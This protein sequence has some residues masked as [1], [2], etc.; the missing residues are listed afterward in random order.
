MMR[1]GDCHGDRPDLQERSR[2]MNNEKLQVVADPWARLRFSV[3]GNLLSSPPEYGKLKEAFKELSMKHWKHPFRDE[4]ITFHWMSI[5]RWYY[6]ARNAE[7]PMEALSRI[8]RS[9]HRRSRIMHPLLLEA[10]HAQYQSHP[11]WSYQLHADNL[12]VYVSERPELG[13][14]PSYSTISRHMK[15][16]GWF[17]K[18]LPGRNPTSGQNAAYEKLEKREIRS[19]ETEYTN[20]L[21]HLDFHVC[22][23]RVVDANGRWNTPHAFCVMDDRSRL[24]CHIQ[25]YLSE[26][27][28][29][30]FH[31]LKQAFFK[32]GLPRAL[33]T[34][35]G[36]AMLARETRNGLE[37][38][39]IVHELTLAYSPYQN[40]KQESFWAVLEGRLMKMLQHVEPLTLDLLNRAT[41]AWA[42]LEYNR[43]EHREIN[44][45]PM[46][47]FLEENSV[48]RKAP[49][50]ERLRMAFCVQEERIQ[51][52]S[53]GTITISNIRFEIP[54]RFRHLQRL[55][56]RYQSWDLSLAYLVDAR[57][58]ILL[59]KIYPLDRTLN[60]TGLRRSVETPYLPNETSIPENTIP[61]LLRKCMADYA[62]NGLPPAFL[63][64][65]ESSHKEIEQTQSNDQE[66]CQDE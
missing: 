58:G 38:L 63:P 64:L 28:M 13:S 22:R 26:S 46:T 20:G 3:I 8:L 2:E 15:M 40:G 51:R 24:C 11:N 41:Q 14:P 29:T 1:T 57:S 6:K 49:N 35:N 18:R 55:T 25:W 42:E 59:S 56:I 48:E 44:T 10:L 7:N 21:W 52:R 16:R 66:T 17:R 47:R 34:D 62:A 19:Y 60:A 61:P 37:Q 12:K 9:D 4:W 30:L 23:S 33:M 43:R 5:E 45:S 31:G 54:S 39:G 32:R 65:Y 53:D 50:E 36:S 27:A